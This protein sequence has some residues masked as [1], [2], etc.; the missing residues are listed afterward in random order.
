VTPIGAVSVVVPNFNG[1]ALLE[2]HLPSLL[3][4]LAGRPG[5]EVIVADAAS[6][7]GS[8]ELLSDR[9]ARQVLVLPSPH[10][11]GFA[12]NCN[13]AVAR[14]RHGV[15]LCLNSDVAVDR[16]FLDPLLRVFDDPGTFAASPAI[17]RPGDCQGGWFNE[18]VHRSFHSFGLVYHSRLEDEDVPHGGGPFPISYACGAAVAF[19]TRVFKS[20]GGFDTLFEPFYWEDVDLC[21][22]AWKRGWRSVYVPQSAVTHEHRGTIGRFYRQTEI[23]AVMERNR[24]LFSWK[25]VTDPVLTAAHFFWTPAKLAEGIAGGRLAVVRGFNDARRLYHQAWSRRTVERR[26]ARHGDR[27]LF[28]MFAAGSRELARLAR[29]ERVARGSGGR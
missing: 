16:G 17:R 5:S 21:Y 13:R 15:V 20:L 4:A 11:V 26:E 24:F 1:A 12:E 28:R 19:R 29:K 25:N 7:D 27:E 2:R 18:S 23:D 9:F 14:A 10:R 6:T 22:R 8:L 3:A